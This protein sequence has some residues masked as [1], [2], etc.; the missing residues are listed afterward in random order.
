MKE[1]TSEDFLVSRGSAARNA[2]E[3]L[4]L[5]YQGPRQRKKLKHFLYFVCFE[6][7]ESCKNKKD[8]LSFESYWRIIANT[9][10]L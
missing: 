5:A 9:K 2:W 10:Y 7:I 4:K 1:K 3:L 8:L 6:N